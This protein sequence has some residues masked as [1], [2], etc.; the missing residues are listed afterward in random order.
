[1]RKTRIALA[2]AFAAVLTV[3]AGT[4]AMA[5]PAAVRTGAAT[6]TAARTSAATTAAATTTFPGVA[7]DGADVIA[8]DQVNSTT[9]N[10]TIDSPAANADIQVQL[11]LPSGWT[12]GAT[13]QT[14]PVLYLLHGC[15]DAFDGWTENTNVQQQTASAPV[16]I[17]LPD[18]GPVGFYSNWLNNGAEGE[19]YETFTA[20]ELPQ[21]LKS[22]FHASNVA[23]IGGVST[24][25]GAALFIAAHNPGVY[26]AVA[27]Y[28]GLDCTELGQSV[29][30]IFAA[31]I[32]ADVNPLDLW[33]PPFEN[34]AAWEQHD[35]CFLAPQLAGTQIFL[36][37][38]TGFTASG[39][40][41]TCSAGVGGNILESVVATGVNQFASD[42]TS[43]DIP[44][45][46]DFYQGGCHDWPFWQTAFT[47]S[48]PM[49]Q[50]ALGI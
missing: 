40:Q 42:L 45:T 20:T 22:G 8:E 6:T 37:V 3:G 14:W 16:I 1:M 34:G 41:T 35:P 28:S 39:Q 32:R 24:G 12:S 48:W 25:G 2:T 21:I 18:G 29:T 46:S 9:L 13:T 33:G 49:L 47:V 5:G 27:S 30:T 19:N 15:C 43:D 36:S 38:G 50:S 44:F 7:A 4:A 23:A 31:M 10:L 11:L 17:A 26:K